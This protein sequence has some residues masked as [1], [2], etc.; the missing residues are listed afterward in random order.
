M[1]NAYNI[2]FGGCCDVF[3]A[4]FDATGSLVFSTYVGG[5]S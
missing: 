1:K 5:I 3:V 2:T 4:K